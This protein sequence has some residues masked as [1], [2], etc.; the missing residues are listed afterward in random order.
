MQLIGHNGLNMYLAYVNKNPINKV[1]FIWEYENKALVIER[2][3]LEVS[4]CRRFGCMCANMQL[5]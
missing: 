4:I 2:V 3:A 5:C 1:G